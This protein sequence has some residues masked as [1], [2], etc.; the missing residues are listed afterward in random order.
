MT[1]DLLALPIV[2]PVGLSSFVLCEDG[3][4]GANDETVA[5]RCSPLPFER[6]H[7]WSR[8]VF[9]RLLR[10]AFS[11]VTAVA[12]ALRVARRLAHTEVNNEREE[13][14]RGDGKEKE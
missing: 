2:L 12:A 10:S 13:E 4:S 11:N 5:P 14:G 9:W 1:T 7:P 8:R 3:A 6:R